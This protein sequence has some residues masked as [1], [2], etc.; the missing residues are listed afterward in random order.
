VLQNLKGEVNQFYRYLSITTIM[1]QLFSYLEQLLLNKRKQ[2]Y[3]KT[4]LKI[5]FLSSV[6]MLMTA[7][8]VAAQSWPKDIPL[9]NGGKITMYQPQ[10]ESLKG[11]TLSARA[12]VSVVKSPGEDPTFGAIWFDAVLETNKDTRT[13]TLESLNVKEAK[14]PAIQDNQLLQQYSQLVQTQVPN[15][16]LQFSLDELLTSIQQEQ[17]LN[18][19]NLKNDAPTIIYRNKPTSLVILDGQPELQMDKT[20]GMQKVVNTPSII[21]KNP[22]D[23]RYYLYGGGLWYSSNSVLNGWSYTPNPPSR[24][25]QLD[26]QIQQQQAKAQDSNASDTKATTPSDI[27][28]STT[29]AELIQTDGD[30]TYQSVSGTNLLYANNSLNDIFKDINTQN[31]YTL[32]SGRW[33]SAPSLNGPWNYVPSDKLPA[34]FAKIPEGSE[35]DGVLASVA[36]TDAAHDAVMDAQIPQTAKVDRKTA[37]LTVTFDGDPIF[38]RIKGTNLMVAE[39][40]SVTVLQ[41]DGRYYAVDNG[42]WYASNSTSGPWSV[43]TERPA[44]VDNIPADNIA[45]NTKYVY[46]YDYSPDYVWTGYTPGYLGCYIYGPTVVWG[47]GWN[48]RPWY[49]HYYYPRPY[50]WGFGMQYNPWSG[51]NIGFGCGFTLGWHYWDSN[52]YWGGWFGPRYYHPAYRSYG[53]NGGYYGRRSAGFLASR[54]NV[55]YNRPAYA[56]NPVG[57]RTN[58]GSYSN[59]NHSVNLYNRVSAARTVDVTRRP[60]NTY[61]NNNP[62]NGNSGGSLHGNGVM[63]T[64]T[65]GVDANNGTRPGN[66]GGVRNNNP[67]S[68]NNN[69]GA[70][71][72]HLIEGAG[73]TRPGSGN[74]VATHPYANP[75]TNQTPNNVATDR[76]GN[77]YRR[78]NNGWQRRTATTPA[79]TGGNAAPA[80]TSPSRQWQPATNNARTED[81]NRVQQQ[82][83]RGVQRESNFRQAQ[84]A[85]P[86]MSAPS[87]PRSSGGGNGGG[88]RSYGGGGGRKGR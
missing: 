44:D 77:V 15:W 48:Y 88:G 20:M 33:Y 17:Q 74:G 66:T 32:L 40:S 19:P 16:D 22:D 39:N 72:G 68:P 28:V 21:V 78:D 6:L 58:M 84:P 29:P 79:N 1:K 54:P 43:A 67:A 69:G 41:S 76:E 75:S 37:T 26:V 60:N 46:I 4:F 18:D 25:Q 12:A 85:A 24:I 50:T 53:W 30:A 42:I 7:M 70:S 11:N 73:G 82:R 81:L 5:G 2:T 45:Y 35:K 56:A 59:R 51:W 65:R 87:A 86:R 34:D 49:R 38:N 10:P 13:A 55:R 27:I 14:F 71:P 63:P 80:N 36:G 64:P 9:D 3:M 23:N 8:T 57:G 52:P 83:D 47:T 62:R 61:V 31:T